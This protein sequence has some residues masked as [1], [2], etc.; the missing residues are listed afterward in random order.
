MG[1]AG[2]CWCGQDNWIRRGDNCWRGILA[3]NVADD[4]LGRLACSKLWRP[5]TDRMAI[6]MTRQEHRIVVST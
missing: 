1:P 4:V 5:T 3:L 2:R 6:K